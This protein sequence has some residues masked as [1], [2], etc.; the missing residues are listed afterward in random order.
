MQ[1]RRNAGMTLF[2]IA[3]SLLILAVAVLSV[4]LAFPVGIKAQQVARFQIYAGAMIT[5]MV[6]S[7]TNADHSFWR[8]QIESEQLAQNTFMATPVDLERMLDNNAM[9]MMPL[10]NEIALRLDSDNNEIAHII[11]EG[12]QIFYTSPYP[13]EVGFDSSYYGNSMGAVYEV[14]PEAQKLLF[15]VV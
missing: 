8:M 2:E 9:G 5:Q 13:T 10:P 3:I 4:G 6:D 15:A 1:S 11:E 7:W 12:G 14:P